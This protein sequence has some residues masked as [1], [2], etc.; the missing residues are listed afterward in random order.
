[1]HSNLLKL[2]ED[3]L[4][5]IPSAAMH[6]GGAPCQE[7]FGDEATGR[8]ERTNAT[9]FIPASVALRKV[10][11]RFRSKPKSC[12]VFVDANFGFKMGFSTQQGDRGEFLVF[13]ESDSK[14]L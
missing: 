12:C 3:N 6:R 8:L 14:Y 13:W 1:M 10:S 4:N 2:P 9:W 5:W 7:R 11:G